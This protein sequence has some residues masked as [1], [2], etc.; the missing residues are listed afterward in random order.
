MP[1][2]R[3]SYNYWP[4]TQFAW[5]LLYHLTPHAK[6]RLLAA[7]LLSATALS[8]PVAT[9]NFEVK[10]SLLDAALVSGAPGAGLVSA[11]ALA[12]SAAERSY[13]YFDTDGRDLDGA[14]WAVRLRHKAG[15]DLQLTYKKRYEVGGSL[16]A[17][18][19]RARDE[20]F[21][22][23]DT[24]YEAQVDWS[25]GRQTLSFAN[26][27]KEPPAGLAGTALPDAGAGL[28]LLADRIPGK[29]E[30]WGSKGWGKDTLR[31]AREPVTA[32]VWDGTWEGVEASVEVLP[33]RT[34]D[35][36]GTEL[37]TEFSFKVDDE[38]TAASLRDKAIKQ[39]DAAGWLDKDGDLKTSLVLDR[40]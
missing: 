26:E 34:A 23:S 35:G 33:V 30:D 18:L 25:Y 38:A 11:L 17:A 14:G 21:D 15:K 10:L 40:Y 36:S 22:A 13:A 6:L 27:K 5:Q 1:D 16:A 31:A 37:F 39:M 24:N 32:R 9:P 28:A 3:G 12:P 29:L 19:A 4:G 7:A 2:A 20:G 8:A